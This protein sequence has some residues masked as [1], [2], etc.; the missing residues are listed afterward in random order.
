MPKR[1]IELAPDATIADIMSSLSQ[2]ENYLIAVLRT[3]YGMKKTQ[4]QV[5]V[6]I[7]VTGQGKMPHYRID[8]VATSKPI[9]AFDFLGEPFPDYRPAETEGWS[10]ESM[11]FA[12][13][14]QLLGEL[15]SVKARGR[16][17]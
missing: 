15:R 7:G 16:N 13:V 8:D 17:A 2:P 9:Q 3:F 14:Q 6:R 11:T 5:S 4:G 1:L 12:G 10:T